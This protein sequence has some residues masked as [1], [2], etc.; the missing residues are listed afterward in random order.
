MKKNSGSAVYLVILVMLVLVAVS[1]LSSQSSTNTIP[2][3][4]FEKMWDSDQISNIKIVEDKMNVLELK[5]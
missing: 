1:F 5:K 4:K 2:Y 3:S